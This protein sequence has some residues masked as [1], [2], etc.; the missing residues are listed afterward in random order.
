MLG[1]LKNEHLDPVLERVGGPD[2]AKVN[3]GEIMNG[4]K[5]IKT[6]FDSKAV[7]AKDVMANIFFKYNQVKND[8][9]ITTV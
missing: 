1:R 7:G 8:A 9:I 4:W 3:Y 5:K 2:G 6:D